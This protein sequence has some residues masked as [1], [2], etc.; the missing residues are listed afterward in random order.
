MTVATRRSTARGSLVA[1]FAGLAFFGLNP[2][3]AEAAGSDRDDTAYLQAK[4][5]AGG[6]VMLRQL[7]DG[8]C[9]QTYG[10]WVSKSKTTIS[11]NGACITYLGPGPARLTSSDGDSIAANAVFFVNRSSSAAKLPQQIAI[12][13]VL[14]HVPA[15]TDGYGVV[16]SGSDITITAITVVGAPFDGVLITG[17]ANG[18][19]YASRVAIRRSTFIGARRNAISVVGAIGVTIDSNT[20]TGAGNPEFLRGASPA[21][22][23]PWAGIDVE[24]DVVGYPLKWIQI[25]NNTISKSH[26]AGVLLDLTT[27]SGSPT[28]ADGIV[29]SRNTIV[30]NGAGAGPPLRGGICL[31]G[32]QAD[33]NGRLIVSTN[34][35]SLNGGF[36]LCNHPEGNSLK[37]SL[38]GNTIHGNTD[39]AS[40]WFTPEAPPAFF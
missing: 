12:S 26:G 24:P 29:V 21:W 35:I 9:Y 15:G 8:A 4:L 25:L 6:K 32:G 22:N 5:D 20:I 11:S 30:G 2:P 27:K 10:L 38:A 1:I 28:T 31:H 37:I 33:G 16:A 18:R 36:G 14:L 34:E 19:G 17:R 13:N 39:G 40:N 7:P 23:G 3:V